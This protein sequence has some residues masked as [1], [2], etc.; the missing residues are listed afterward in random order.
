MKTWNQYPVIYEINIWVWLSELQGKYN[1]ILDL[2]TI[3]DEEWDTI[4]S[5]GFDAVWFM[6]VWERIPAG[7]EI[8]MLNNGLIEDFRRALPISRTQ[9]TQDQSTLEIAEQYDGIRCDVTMLVL[10]IIFECTRGA[11]AGAKLFED[12]RMTTI[13][14]SRKNSL[15]LNLSPRSNGIWSGFFSGRD[16]TSAMTR[17][18]MI[19]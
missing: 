10:N 1:R 13:R 17:S 8:F 2:S 4:A 6:G 5:Y 12:Y 11:R 9:T 15:S 14:L 3:P 7:I 18:C 16:S 19:G